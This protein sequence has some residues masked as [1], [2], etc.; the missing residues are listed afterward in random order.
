MEKITVTTVLERRYPTETSIDLLTTE[1]RCDSFRAGPG[2]DSAPITLVRSQVSL[3]DDTS[4]SPVLIPLLRRLND[5]LPSADVST[6]VH[7][8]AD[9]ATPLLGAAE[10]RKLLFT[11]A[12]YEEREVCELSP[13]ISLAAFC[14][15]SMK[16]SDKLVTIRSAPIDDAVA[17]TAGICV[18]TYDAY[19]SSGQFRGG[20]GAAERAVRMFGAQVRMF[21]RDKSRRSAEM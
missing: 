17:A 7:S 16:I 6:V 3:T 14:V 9:T 20:L 4:I 11:I 15:A 13:T 1:P 18:I 21:T 5:S 19:A 12:S 10:L 2:I 8:A